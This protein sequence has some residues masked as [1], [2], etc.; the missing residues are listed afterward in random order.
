MEDEQYE[1]MYWAMSPEYRQAT[2][3]ETFTA[4]FENDKRLNAGLADENIALEEKQVGADTQLRI[5]L[6]YRNNRV[7]PR[8]VTVRTTK[9]P[10]G[11]RLIES[12][13]IPI[14]L[15]NL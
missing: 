9:T 1:K 7:K 10:N 11:H 2:T 6:V 15:E 3:L 8:E 4:L 14:D 13:I 12:G 5:T